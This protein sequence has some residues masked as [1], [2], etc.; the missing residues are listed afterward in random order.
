MEITVLMENNK[1]KGSDFKTENGPSLLIEDKHGLIL[2]DTGGP[3][4]YAI[5]NAPKLGVDLSKVDAV[6]ISH[7]H[8]DHTGGLLSFFKMNDKAPVYLKKEAL[9]PYY[10]KLPD[11]NQIHWYG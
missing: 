7:G 11:K 1:L 6:V 3:K 8:N 9:N 5:Q 10:A 4:N 2:F